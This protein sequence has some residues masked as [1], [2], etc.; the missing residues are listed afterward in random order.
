MIGHGAAARSV[1]NGVAG[2]AADWLA[3]TGAVGAAGLAG[4]SANHIVAI[5]TVVAI[6]LAQSAV[7]GDFS[8]VP[9]GCRPRRG[10]PRSPFKVL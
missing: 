4:A 1:A 7:R 2:A 8:L 6:G 10:S 9:R 3:A 5:G